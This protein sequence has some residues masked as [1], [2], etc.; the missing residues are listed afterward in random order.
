MNAFKLFDAD[1]KGTLH[2]D[3][4][5]LTAQGN[6][7]ERLTDQQFNQVL[8]GAPID[9]KGNMDYATFVRIIKRGKQDDE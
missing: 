5:I 1:A 7:A 8:E 6:P 9:N 4:E 2:R 3:V